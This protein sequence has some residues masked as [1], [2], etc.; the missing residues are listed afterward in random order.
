[1][2]LKLY[3]GQR[4]LENNTSWAAVLIGGEHDIGVNE[5]EGIGKFWGKSTSEVNFL[6][7]PRRV[8]GGGFR[9]GIKSNNSA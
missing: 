6:A 2:T 1:M 9:V 4:E 8:G 5:E 7:V 3:Y